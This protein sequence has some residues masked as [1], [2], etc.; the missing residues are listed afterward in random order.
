MRPRAASAP[1]SQTAD[2]ARRPA[3][4]GGS[5]KARSPGGFDCTGHAYLVGL[6]L[7]RICGL[8]PE[9]LLE[10]LFGRGTGHGLGAGR[11]T[12]GEV[13]EA[14]DGGCGQEFGFSGESRERLGEHD[15]EEDFDGLLEYESEEQLNA[16]EY[17]EFGRV[18]VEDELELPRELVQKQQQKGL[19]PDSWS[20]YFPTRPDPSRR[21]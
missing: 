7:Q 15:E 6:D 4:R 21:F 8:L 13:V 5:E 3:T 14:G 1:A 11:G 19:G 16:P 9:S 20:R 10:G 18:D 12:R 2:P 17:L